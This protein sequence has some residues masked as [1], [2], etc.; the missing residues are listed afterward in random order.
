[1]LNKLREKVATL[2]FW[3]AKRSLKDG[4]DFALRIEKDAIIVELLRGKFEGVRFQFKNVILR[5][6][7]L[8]DFQTVIVD[9]PH[10]AKVTSKKFNKLS[11]NL[12]RVVLSECVSDA[13]KVI[14]E[15]RTSDTVKPVEEREFHEEVSPLLEKRISSGQSRKKAV[16]PDTVVHPEIQQ[17]AKSKRTG[18]RTPRA[19]RPK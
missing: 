10:C 6:D 13:S 1:M 7:R 9:N 2:E 12:F 17:H 18:T 8:V 16:R 19:K 3:W 14:N 5:E 15:S 11:A 4:V